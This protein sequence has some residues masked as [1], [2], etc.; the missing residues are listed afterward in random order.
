[1]IV[2]S[3]TQ[4]AKQRGH[5]LVYHRKLQEHLSRRICNHCS[6]S[7]ME[8]HAAGFKS[9]MVIRVQEEVLQVLWEK[10]YPSCRYDRKNEAGI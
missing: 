9:R 6:Y 3:A 1:M 5:Q 4:Q 2:E 8:P 10:Q 7:Q